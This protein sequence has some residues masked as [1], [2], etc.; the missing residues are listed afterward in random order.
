MELSVGRTG[1]EKAQTAMSDKQDVG[2]SRLTPGCA[3][4][5]AQHDLIAREGRRLWI[6]M[7][8]ILFAKRKEAAET[9]VKLTAKR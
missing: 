6:R 9:R 3:E 4:A 8:V 5:R 2:T 7:A 1:G